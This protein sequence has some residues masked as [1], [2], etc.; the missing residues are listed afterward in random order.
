MR[1]PYSWI[2]DSNDHL[3]RG[4]SGHYGNLSEETRVVTGQT[5][6]TCRRS[7]ALGSNTYGKKLDLWTMHVSIIHDSRLQQK[8]KENDMKKKR[9]S[10]SDKVKDG[11]GFRS[12]IRRFSVELCIWYMEV[13]IMRD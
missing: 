12:A 1:T 5:A 4:S 3:N 6:R 2:G 11:I 13:I 9:H 10:A 7:A 8:E